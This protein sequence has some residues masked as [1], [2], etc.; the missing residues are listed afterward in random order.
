MVEFGL[1]LEDNKVAEWSDSYINYEKLKALLK[2]AKEA[3]KK[4]DELIKRRPDL[5]LEIQEAYKAGDL[6]FDPQSGAPSRVNSAVD[7][8]AL[9]GDET[10]ASETEK[11]L[12]E[13]SFPGSLKYGS[14]G[15]LRSMGSGEYKTSDSTVQSLFRGVSGYFSKSKYEKKLGYALQAVDDGHALFAGALRE[16]V[17]FTLTCTSALCK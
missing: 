14:Q 7:L 17:R 11:L 13:N 9:G 10:N 16:E 15:S 1:K 8:A 2:K 5:A 12:K 4:R 3:A 6:V